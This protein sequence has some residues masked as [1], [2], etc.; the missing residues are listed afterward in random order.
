MRECEFLRC[1]DTK[2]PKV[3]SPLSVTATDKEDIISHSKAE[4][5]Y[6]MSTLKLLVRAAM[7]PS[8]AP[9]CWEG[10]LVC[11]CHADITFYCWNSDMWRGSK[12]FFFRFSLKIRCREASRRPLEQ[13]LWYRMVEASVAWL[14]H[15]ILRGLGFRLPCRGTGNWVRILEDLRWS[16]FATREFLAPSGLA[17]PPRHY[18]LS[19]KSART[20][21]VNV[22]SWTIRSRLRDVGQISR[23][24]A[25]GSVIL[26][27]WGRISGL[28][29]RTVRNSSLGWVPILSPIFRWTRKDDDWRKGFCM[30][31][32]IMD[33][34]LRRFSNCLG[35][36]Q[37]DCPN[38]PCPCGTTA[39]QYIQDK[40]KS[41]LDHLLVIISCW[42]TTLC[43]ALYHS[44]L[45]W[46]RDQSYTLVST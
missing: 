27:G 19:Q 17:Q 39:H 24:P 11:G 40:N 30:H 34:I 36:N 10:N 33:S 7:D 3:F 25:T 16:I 8:R 14:K 38:G 44:V 31:I 35:R 15:C 2:L 12:Q 9:K 43:G 4:K 32:F 28:E 18:K 42:W 22:S 46:S 6:I 23:R 41:S 29:Q 26:A 45:E 20:R 21:G 37:F 1:P 13:W 5:L